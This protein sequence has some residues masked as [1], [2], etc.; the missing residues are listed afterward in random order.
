MKDYCGP[1]RFTIHTGDKENA[2]CKKHDEAYKNALY[3]F[4]PS[5]ADQE[6]IEALGKT[7]DKRMDLARRFFY[8]KNK[9]W[10]P[11]AED[12]TSLYYKATGKEPTP[13]MHQRKES[14]RAKRHKLRVQRKEAIMKR[15]SFGSNSGMSFYILHYECQLDT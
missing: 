5:Q 15:L 11:K 1:G 7:E 13:D 6:L 3:Y 8:L 4:F 9:V 12:L 2:A 14:E 10:L